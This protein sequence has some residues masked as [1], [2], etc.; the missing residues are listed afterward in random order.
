MFFFFNDTATTEIYTL[1]LHDAL[2]ISQTAAGR[3]AG[4]QAGPRCSSSVAGTLRVDFAG[5]VDN[6]LWSRLGSGPL[7]GLQVSR[8]AQVDIQAVRAELLKRREELRN[9]ASRAS[10]D[11]RHESD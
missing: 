9:R 2:P 3:R 4:R 10:A 8:E 5:G 6:V 11:L 1:S 7:F